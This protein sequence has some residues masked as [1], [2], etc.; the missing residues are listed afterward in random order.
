MPTHHFEVTNHKLSNVY[1]DLCIKLT[2][3]VQNDLKLKGLSVIV[4]SKLYFLPNPQIFFFFLCIFRENFIA[5]HTTTLSETAYV[6]KET[7]LCCW[8]L[9]IVGNKP[10]FLV[11]NRLNLDFLKFVYFSIWDSNTFFFFNIILNYK[12]WLYMFYGK[13]NTNFILKF[14]EI[15]LWRETVLSA[16]GMESDKNLFFCQIYAIF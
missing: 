9:I 8:E 4:N 2:Y 13:R 15:F 7:I 1:P 11:I 12:K 14:R 5:Y 6:W 3:W 10:V 16:H